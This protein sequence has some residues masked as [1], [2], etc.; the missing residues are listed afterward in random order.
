[1]FVFILRRIILSIPIFFG[2]TL[3]TFF[4]IYIAPGDY[5]DYMKLDNSYNP[6]TIAKIKSDYKLDE[7]FYTQYF[8]WLNNIV[9]FDLGYSF[10]R[11]AKVSS[12]ITTYIFNTFLLASSS[13]IVIWVISIILGVLCSYYRETWIDKTFSVLSYMGITIPGF[14]LSLLLLY[15]VF[16]LKILPLNGMVSTGYEDLTLLEKIF[17]ILKHMVI[18]VTVISIMGVASYQ[19]VLRSN[20]LDELNKQYILSARSRGVGE[21]RILFKHALRNALNP[22][23]TKFGH[24][25]A[26]LLGGVAVIEI[27]CN[28]PGIGKITLDAMIKQDIFLS[29]GGIIISSMFLIVG[30]IISDILLSQVNP[31][32]RFN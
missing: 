2:V 18:P 23:I 10:S 5:F 27:V 4:L 28:W 7:P 1:M 8:S 3:I 6:E 14:L 26:S 21:K 32:I 19:R 22:L 20:M 25:F 12:I 11:K 9:S 24:D 13:I 15:I 17:D 30:N 29:L 16:Y 31:K